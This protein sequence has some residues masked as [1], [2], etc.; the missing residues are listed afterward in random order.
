MRRT[1]RL[2]AVLA[3][4]V[5]A[6]EQARAFDD[7]LGAVISQEREITG[8][9]EVLPDVVRDREIDVTL[10]MGVIGE[11]ATRSRVQ[12]EPLRLLLPVAPALPR[13]QGSPQST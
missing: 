4:I 3:F 7:Q 5:T 6:R 1:I 13:I 10:E 2:F 11:P 9:L 12:M 8:D